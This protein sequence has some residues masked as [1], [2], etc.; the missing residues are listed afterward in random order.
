MEDHKQD[1][2]DGVNAQ[3]LQ[4]A[5]LPTPTKQD[6]RHPQAR[7]SGDWTAGSPDVKSWSLEDVR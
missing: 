2:Y 3:A 5:G 1:V 7:I 4:M 6:E